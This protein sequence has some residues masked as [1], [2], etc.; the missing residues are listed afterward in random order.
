MSLIDKLAERTNL[1]R[2]SIKRYALTCPRRYKVYS[3]PKRNGKGIRVIAQPSPPVK[4][5]QRELVDILK[6]SMP[7][8]E[9]AMAYRE[10][11]SILDN[12]NRHKENDFILKMDFSNFFPSIDPI[13]VIA[14]IRRH[15]RF[16]VDEDIPVVTSI[17]FR[18]PR[19][20]NRYE[21]SIGAPSSPFISNTFMF[22]FDN[23]VCSRLIE[24]RI[25]Y[26]RYADD[27]TFSTNK[28]GLLFGIP[29][30]IKEIIINLGYNTLN[31]NDDKTVFSSKKH[32]R[33]VTG[34]VLTN[35]RKVSIG[36]AKKREIRTLIFK[37]LNGDLTEAEIQALRGWVAHARHIEP[38]FWKRLQ[39]KY[40]LTNDF[41]KS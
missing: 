15:S 3:I 20:T 17:L 39:A 18:R 2:E 1:P 12:A 33:H 34:L 35:E 11:T 21:L 13:A 6:E 31:I 19:G 4:A 32:N 26:T 14:H 25:T 7:V 24:D 8:H 38:D 37:Y 27:L 16:I 30:A 10:G 41:F 29:K 9:N 23:A 28:K 40:K 22:E 5:L 36:R